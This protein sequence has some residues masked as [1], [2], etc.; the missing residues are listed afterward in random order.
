V[1]CECSCR[2][3][4]FAVDTAFAGGD[5]FFSRGRVDAGAERCQAQHT[6][7]LGRDC[8]GAVAFREG[9][10]FH[11]CP[12]QAAARSQEGDR[13]D[14]I[15]LADAIRAREHNRPGPIKLD[16]CSMIA[17]EISQRQATNEGGGH[18]RNQ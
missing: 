15:G 6:L 5:G 3:D 2:A 11:R 7:D 12:P 18:V 4:A 8:P 13:F 17:A 1:I 9:Q 16:L 14:Q 10:L